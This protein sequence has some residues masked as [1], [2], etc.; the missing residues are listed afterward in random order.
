MLCGCWAAY[1]EG[2]RRGSVMAEAGLLRGHQQIRHSPAVELSHGIDLEG[3]HH[4]ISVTATVD[5][6]D[7][8]DAHRSPRH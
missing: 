7:L 2:A 5:V 3:G 6:A 1:A 4:R 8:I